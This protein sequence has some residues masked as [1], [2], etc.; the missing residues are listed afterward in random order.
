VGRGQ[1]ARRPGPCDGRLGASESSDEPVNPVAAAPEG[2]AIAAFACPK[3]GFHRCPRGWS[4]KEASP[5][6]TGSRAHSSAGSA[7]ARMSANVCRSGVGLS[8]LGCV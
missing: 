6:P 3:R 5:L 2:T 4:P 8:D 1:K 7:F